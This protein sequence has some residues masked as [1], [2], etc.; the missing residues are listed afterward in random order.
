MFITV[1]E[2]NDIVHEQ[3]NGYQCNHHRPVD[4]VLIERK[5]KSG[6]GFKIV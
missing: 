5:E 4:K 1:D 2:K 3:I 6:T